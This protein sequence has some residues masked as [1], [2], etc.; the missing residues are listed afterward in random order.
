MFGIW[1]TLLALEVVAFHLL[2]LPFIGAY[3]VFSFFVLSGF[4]MTA[5]VHDTYGY[6]VGGFAR[7]IGNRALRLY[8]SYWFALLTSIL[9]VA[10]LGGDT[11]LHYHPTIA[12]PERAADWAQNLAMIFVD[13]VPR[14]VWPR[15]VP[16]AWALTVEIV[17][18]VL[19][20]VGLSRTKC[21]SWL[22]FLASIGYVI[23]ATSFHHLRESANELIPIY[24]YSAI[25]AGSLS[26]STGSLVWHYRTEIQHQLD[27]FW[28]GDARLL[29]VS[30][31][32]FYL[33]IAFV[34]ALFG[35]KIL[36]MAG[37]W[38][39]VGLSGLIVCA[40]FH[41]RP[42]PRSRRVDKAVGDYS[43]PIYLLHLQMGIVAAAL[44]FGGPVAGR[45]LRS[46]AVFVLGLLLTL[47]VSSICTRM[48]DPSVERLRNRIRRSAA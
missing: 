19:I 12:L 34:Q 13:I 33:T 35:W 46:V 30:R 32:G 21:T 1:R 6:S 26:F 15:L 38:I 3:A 8:P 17:F 10:W 18:Y 31:W 4:L 22:W 48:I 29:V 9:L 44:L 41:R 5:I 20:G 43:Y 25:P 27:R 40:L 39:N 37:N 24:Q 42:G 36:V 23:L 14:D 47:L 16:L 11:I 2:F 7:Y 28:I 45:S